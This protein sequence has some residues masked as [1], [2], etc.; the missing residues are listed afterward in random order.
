MLD[1]TLAL[2]Y[3]VL[4]KMQQDAAGVVL[5]LPLKH[6]TKLPGVPRDPFFVAQGLAL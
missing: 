1:Y 3:G 2:D 4:E 5:L 6:S